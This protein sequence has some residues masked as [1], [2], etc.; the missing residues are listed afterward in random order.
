[1]ATARTCTKAPCPVLLLWLG[2]IPLSYGLSALAAAAAAAAALPLPLP[3]LARLFSLL[4]FRRVSA[5]A[6]CSALLKKGERYSLSLAT[7]S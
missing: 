6:L 1:M 5:P 4:V 2:A 3:W 7:G